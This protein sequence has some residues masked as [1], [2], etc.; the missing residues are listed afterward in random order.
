MHLSSLY[1]F[2]SGASGAPDLKQSLKTELKAYSETMQQA[3]GSVPI[4]VTEDFPFVLGPK[5]LSL[6][7]N[8]F[9]NLELTALELGYIVDAIQ[10]SDSVEFEN[11]KVRDLLHQLTDPE[12]NGPII[13]EKVKAM[14]RELNVIA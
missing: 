13:E 12:I 1:K 11:E 10:L 14:L 9:L 2:L 5:E 6:L 8:S 3:G 7:M 4:H